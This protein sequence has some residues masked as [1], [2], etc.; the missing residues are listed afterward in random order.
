MNPHD[1][2]D[3]ALA[4]DPIDALSHAIPELVRI[5]EQ[6]RIEHVV[7]LRRHGANWGFIGRT[8][9]MT[10]QGALQRYGHWTT[11]TQT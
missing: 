5:L 1:L 11:P 2:L 3:T 6:Q 9:G 8:L 4:G 10:R 7:T